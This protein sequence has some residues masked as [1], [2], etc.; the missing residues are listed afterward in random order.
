MARYLATVHSPAEL[1]E[2]WSAVGDFSAVAEWDPGVTRAATLTDG[3]IGVGTRYRVV[4]HFLGRDVPLEYE[5]V[6]YEP[7]SRLRVRA[8]NGM[9]SSDDTIT[10]TAGDHG[11]TVRYDA[12]LEGRGLARLA[13][14]LLPM[15]LNRIGRQAEA[16]L[17]S[18]VDDV[19]TLDHSAAS[20]AE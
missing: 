2:V 5:V 11:T 3:P 17:Q 6:E 12:R 14:P 9:V 16:G 15:A 7:R 1:D 18:F 13:T 4:S 19:A 20:P 10:F 8:E